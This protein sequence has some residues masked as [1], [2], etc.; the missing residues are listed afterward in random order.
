MATNKWVVVLR[1]DSL[2]NKINK[3]TVEFVSECVPDLQTLNPET[4]E[5]EEEEDELTLELGDCVPKKKR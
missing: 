2:I 5:G 4:E 3:D 1:K